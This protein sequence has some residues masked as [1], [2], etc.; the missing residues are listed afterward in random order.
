MREALAIPLCIRVLTADESDPQSSTQTMKIREAL[1]G[2]YGDIGDIPLEF[3]I[4]EEREAPRIEQLLVIIDD[5]NAIAGRWQDE[6]KSAL[7]GRAVEEASDRSILRP[8]EQVDLVPLLILSHGTVTWEFPTS[9]GGDEAAAKRFFGLLNDLAELNRE[10]QSLQLSEDAAA[11][12]AQ[13]KDWFFGDLSDYNDLRRLIQAKG[14]W[15]QQLIDLFGAADYLAIYYQK[16]GW[17]SSIR[18]SRNDGVPGTGFKFQLDLP[19]FRHRRERPLRS[20]PTG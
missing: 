15:L 19:T 1:T 7:E 9:W 11:G 16:K 6:R 20:S 3:L 12:I 14:A 10:L 2:F 8:L 4:Q 5:G 13:S 18:L 17:H